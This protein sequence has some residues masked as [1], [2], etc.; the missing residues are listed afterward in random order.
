MKVIFAFWI[1]GNVCMDLE[2]QE[3][4]FPFLPTVGNEVLLYDYF[5]EVDFEFAKSIPL[6]ISGDKKMPYANLM[7][8]LFDYNIFEVTKVRWISGGVEI[9][10][11]LEDNNNLEHWNFKINI[12]NEDDYTGRQLRNSI[13]VYSNAMNNFIYQKN[14][15]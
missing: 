13:P 10:I 11:E 15:E 7:E 12:P 6:I 9:Q 5:N 14:K 2:I 1:G 8:L 4:K 3:W